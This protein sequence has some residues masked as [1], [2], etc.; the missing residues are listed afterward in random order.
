MTP[1]TEKKTTVYLYDYIYIRI[2]LIYIYIQCVLTINSRD[3]MDVT[4]NHM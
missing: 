4:S 3:S 1:S 2:S